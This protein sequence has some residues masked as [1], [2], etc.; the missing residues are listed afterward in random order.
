MPPGLSA[1]EDSTWQQL[2]VRLDPASPGARAVEA[3]LGA[4]LPTTP[5][6]SAATREGDVVWLGPDEWLVLAP[7]ARPVPVPALADAVRASGGSVVDVSAQRTTLRLTGPAV[8][9][10]LRGGC[11]VDLHRSVF[12]PGTAV[13][14]SIAQI[15]VLL[16]ARAPGGTDVTVLVR[17]TFA[18]ALADWILDAAVEASAPGPL[19]DGQGGA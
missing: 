15:G 7:G 5:S 8:P 3:L 2:G 10:L 9:D 16:L 18:G 13:Q 6:T 14:T 17:S 1:S 12:A 19:D 4:A 11:A